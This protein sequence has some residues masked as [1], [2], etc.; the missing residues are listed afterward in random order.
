MCL[1]RTERRVL[2]G[3]A[4]NLDRKLLTLVQTD[5]ASANLLSAN[6]I[7]G[8]NASEVSR[9]CPPMYLS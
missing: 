3:S 7:R 9:P 6:L 5:L 1:S 2:S 4:A 8:F